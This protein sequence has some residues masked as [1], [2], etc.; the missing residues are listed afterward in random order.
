MRWNLFAAFGVM[1]LSF[2][3][4]VIVACSSGESCK[5]NTLNFQIVLSGTSDLADTVT[6]S[7]VDPDP[8]LMFS[9]T[10]AHTPGDFST[11]SIDVSWPAGYPADKLVHLIVKASGGVTTLA[12]N[13]ATIHLD[14]G[15]TT[16]HV[17]LLGNA[18]PDAASTD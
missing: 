14:P 11:L 6:I 2:V 17:V 7:D 8:A 5:K 1:A 15:C 16:A 10:F 9:Q 12:A 13:A 4:V 18:I 3:A